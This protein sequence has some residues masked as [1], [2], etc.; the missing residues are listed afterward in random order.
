M[1][2]LPIT[3]ISHA[4]EE[5]ARAMEQLSRVQVFL[6]SFRDVLGRY[7]APTEEREGSQAERISARN[8]EVLT[9]AER[10][11]VLMKELNRPVWPKA[12][13]AEYERRRWP[14]P[15]SGTVYDAVN[16]AMSYLLH[17]RHVLARNEQGY[18]LPSQILPEQAGGKKAGKG[19]RA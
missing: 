4:N 18:F 15:R 17:R 13:A 8:P 5:L 2:K 3:N 16:G 12:V 1:M 14:A 6:D 19:A 10:V 9:L 11:L 7:S